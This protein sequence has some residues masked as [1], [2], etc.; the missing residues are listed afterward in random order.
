M[1]L[2]EPWWQSS[3]TVASTKPTVYIMD[4]ALILDAIIYLSHIGCQMDVR[5]GKKVC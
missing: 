1:P 3:S 2:F 5:P 4:W